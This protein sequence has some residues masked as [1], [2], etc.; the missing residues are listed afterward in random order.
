MH[1]SGLHYWDPSSDIAKTGTNIKT[2]KLTFVET[3][4]E[5]KKLY[6][7]RQVKMAEIA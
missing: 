6:S 5:R 4:E 2:K 3:V 1:E 7:K